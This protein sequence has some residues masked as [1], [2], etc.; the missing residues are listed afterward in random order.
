M[1]QSLT[2]IA[3][4]RD[5]F[6]EDVEEAGLVGETRNATL[7]LFCSVSAK[8]AKPLHLTVQASSSAGKNYLLSSVAAFLPPGWAKMLSG[9]TPKAL[10]HSAEDEYEHK[11]VFI[12]EY[13]GVAGADYAIRTFQS[14]RVIEWEFVDSSKGFKKRTNRVR[15]PAAF[16]QATTRPVLHPE[17]ETRLLFT[18]MDESPEQTQAILRRQAREAAIGAQPPSTELFQPW[19]QLISGLK[20]MSVLIPFAPKLA[21]HFPTKLV[22]SRRDF[23]KLL[24]LVEVSAFL[25]QHA[26]EVEGTSVIAHET[27]Y[28]IAKELFEH[29]YSAMPDNVVSELVS[30]AA[31]AQI[32][33]NDFAA[34][35]LIR[36][37]GWG[38][39]KTYAVMTRAE[40]LGCIANSSWGRYVFL[41]N[42]T[43]DEIALPSGI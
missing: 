6:S 39:S 9:M 8:L 14:E 21:M 32:H 12:A 26:R 17:N 40:E 31:L 42:H 4:L 15:G 10:M 13:E 41:R 23:P 30:A 3:D 11:P 7:V 34:V 25:H 28:L 27:D 2:E 5:R 1:S 22:R 36:S 24:G 20:S 38:K 16:I 18:C 43:N 19:Q 35:D 29:C 37:L 33:G